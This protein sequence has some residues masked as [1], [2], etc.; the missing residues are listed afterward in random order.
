MEGKEE[1]PLSVILYGEQPVYCFDTS[2]FIH[3]KKE[4]RRATFVS[5]WGDL[6]HL[7]TARRVVAPREVLRELEVKDDD[8]SKWAKKLYSELF[9]ELNEEQQ[10]K[11]KE[12]LRDYPRLVDPLKTIPE[13]D[14]FVISLAYLDGLIVVTRETPNNPGPTGSPSIPDV[15]AGIG[16][17]C[18]YKIPDFFER[19]KWQY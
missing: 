17:E 11:V 14:P 16:V 13:A 15:C 2:A 3:L 19:E 7:V 4:Y 1:R 8:L 9:I 10:D 6:E 12:V 5:L 18:I